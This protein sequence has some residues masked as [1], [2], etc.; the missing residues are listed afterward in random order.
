MQIGQEAGAYARANKSADL[1]YYASVCSPV[2]GAL[3]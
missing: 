2:L 3:P 1:D